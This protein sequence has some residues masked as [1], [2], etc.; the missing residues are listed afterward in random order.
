MRM[1]TVVQSRVAL[2][3]KSIGIR[4]LTCS[5]KRRKR[6]CMLSTK[7]YTNLWEV[8]QKHHRRRLGRRFGFTLITL[9][10]GIPNV[11]LMCIISRVA[12]LRLQSKTSSSYRRAT[13]R[14]P[15]SNQATPK[16]KNSCCN[17]VRE[18]TM[19]SSLTSNFHSQFFRHLDLP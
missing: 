18:I 5:P 15:S 7:N 19:N 12:L 9:H 4:S 6:I 8:S 1:M 10:L 3:P 13:R 11:T 2:T 17:S 16:S 14:I